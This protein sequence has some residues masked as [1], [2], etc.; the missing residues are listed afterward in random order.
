MARSI[1]QRTFRLFFFVNLLFL[2]TTLMFAWWALEDLEETMLQSDREV[3]LDYFRENGDKSTPQRTVTA[4][5]VSAFV[6]TGLDEADYLPVVFRGLPVPFQ[7]EIEFL[8]KEYF[9]VTQNF[10]DGNYYLAKDLQLFEE[11]EDT[12]VLYV[13]TLALLI[14]VA[15]FV[16]ASIFSK[17][18]SAPVRKF[19]RAITQL[20][21]QDTNSRL[22]DNFVDAELNEVA[23]AVNLYLD[24]IES[25]VQREKTMINLASHELRT[26]VS[27]ILGAA[28]IIESRQRVGADDAKT[29]QRIIQAA[30]EMSA[31]IRTLLA[32]MR[33]GSED[34][35]LEN[36][37]LG[38]LL[39]QLCHSYTMENPANATRLHFSS[40]E[41][42]VRLAADKA[43]VRMLLHNLISN[44]LSHTEGSVTISLHPSHI[45]V[46][47]QGGGA[48][49]PLTP[50]SHDPKLASGL[51]LYIVNLACQ[52]LGWRV[53]VTPSSAGTSIRVTF[54]AASPDLE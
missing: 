28:R 9:V 54:L 29:L 53:E 16:L 13:L 50:P 52:K 6:P 21:E 27:V 14:C 38:E 8:G 31:N 35:Q 40:P 37:S 43:L 26:P 19:A 20:D 32:L 36:F 5:L 25:S 12:L 4:Q 34:M 10:E 41:Q 47:D 1:A 2:T 39:E 42:D 48:D 51:G 33:Q 49:I 46:R 30:E 7:G 18:I 45:E 3:E 44:A 24:R 22:Q 11:R 23:T 17:R 15:C